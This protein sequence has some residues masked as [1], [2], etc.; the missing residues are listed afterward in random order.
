MVYDEMAITEGADSNEYV[1]KDED[2]RP[3]TMIVS[4]PHSYDH[5]DPH[6]NVHPKTSQNSH[7]LLSFQLM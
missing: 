3:R 6:Q 7:S 2:G 4:A 1:P 5:Y